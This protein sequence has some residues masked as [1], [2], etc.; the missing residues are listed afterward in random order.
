M[1]HEGPATEVEKWTT[2]HEVEDRAGP[3]D[4]IPERVEVS[5]SGQVR[6]QYGGTCVTLRPKA[7][8]RLAQDG[9]PESAHIDALFDAI[10]WHFAPHDA[11]K[12]RERYRRRMTESKPIRLDIEA[13]V[14]RVLPCPDQITNDDV[15]GDPESYRFR[16]RGNNF[17]VG[18]TLSVEEYGDGSLK[19]TDLAILLQALLKGK[20]DA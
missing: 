8:V 14:R 20:G 4:R 10:N 6:I 3:G 7:W 5:E 9:I 13:A 17:R 16:W 19:G 11:A 1:S 18:K 15:P 2:I 12:V